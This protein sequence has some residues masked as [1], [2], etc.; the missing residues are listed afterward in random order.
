MD[1]KHAGT[2]TTVTKTALTVSLIRY[3]WLSITYHLG[4]FACPDGTAS[5]IV[6]VIFGILFWGSVIAGCVRCICCRGSGNVDQNV[7]INNANIPPPMQPPMMQPVQQPVMVQQPMVVQ[8]PIMMQQP[9][10]Q[11]MQQPMMMQQ[12][13]MPS[14]FEKKP[15]KNKIKYRKKLKK[16]K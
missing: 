1:I 2:M 4:D 12:Q 6:W 11:S 7:M 16:V 10:Q 9:M 3:S 5:A 13:P 15:S 8:Q 14:G